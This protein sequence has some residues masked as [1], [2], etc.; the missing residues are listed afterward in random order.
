MNE[1]E[2]RRHY[3]INPGDKILVERTDYA[4]YIFYKTPIRNRNRSGHMDTF[5]KTL[6]FPKGTQVEN[7]TT[8]IVKDFFE[9][10]YMG[11]DKYNAVWTLVITDY[12]EYEETSNGEAIRNYLDNVE[13][14]DINYLDVVNETL[15]F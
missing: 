6:I 1:E 10:V 14:N 2:H 3:K 4:G 12:E 5:Y 9:G 15:P 7:G 11:R 13:D 8:I